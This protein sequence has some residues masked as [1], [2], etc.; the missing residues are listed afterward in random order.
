MKKITFLLLLTAWCF[1]AFAQ[2][3][4]K[5]PRYLSTQK[6]FTF[7]VQPFQLFN[8]GFRFDFETRLGNGPGWLQFGPTIYSATRDNDYYF[9]DNH[10]WHNGVF[11]LREPFTQLNGAGL[12]I[13]YKRFI[14][15]YRSLYFASGLSYT[16]FNLD[17]KRMG[18]W[19]DYTEDGLLYHAY[20][21]ERNMQT[22]HIDRMAINGYFGFQPAARHGFLFDMFIGFSYRHAEADKGKPQFND[23]S[24]SY[25]F[26]GF[27][28]MAG[29]RFGVGIK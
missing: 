23:Y 13:N 28:F 11:Y 21:Y 19:R 3:Q 5:A 18:D 10:R 15:P 12:D 25:G 26:T 24:Y 2:E 17:Y 7:A 29:I 6:K 14:D 1:V 4:E 8:W 22:Q 20:I 16:R 9:I 27:V